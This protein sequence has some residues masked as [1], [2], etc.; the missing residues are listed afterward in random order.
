MLS[1][2]RS[3]E[4]K[5]AEHLSLWFGQRGYPE[6][7]R[8][9]ILGRAGPD[10]DVNEFKLVVDVKSRKEI[11]KC[12]YLFPASEIVT[13]EHLFGIKLQVLKENNFPHGIKPTKS[14]VIVDDYFY[15]MEEWTKIYV[16]DGITAIVLHR[17]GTKVDTSVLVVDR[18]GYSRIMEAHLGHGN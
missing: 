18:D 11:P 12:W 2:P 16:P 4:R 6:V 17:P 9:P 8:I 5:V 13:N 14:S 1:R 10:I 3:I 7:K 15:H